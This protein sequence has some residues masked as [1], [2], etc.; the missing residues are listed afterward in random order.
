MPLTLTGILCIECRGAMDS[1]CEPLGLADAFKRLGSGC[2]CKH[3]ACA[4]IAGVSVEVTLTFESVTMARWM[5][6]HCQH[7]SSELVNS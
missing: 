2:L 5:C 3:P 4:G 7:H 1:V 6:Q